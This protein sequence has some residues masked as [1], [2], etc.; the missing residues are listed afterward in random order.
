MDA[1]R[2]AAGVLAPAGILLSPAIGTLLMSVST[3][4]VALNAQLLRRA[5][6][7]GLL[8]RGPDEKSGAEA[9]V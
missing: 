7:G 2:V 6:M 3:A 9:V 8:R 5:R 4:V 1:V